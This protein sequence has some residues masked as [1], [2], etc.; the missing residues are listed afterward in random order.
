MPKCCRN[1]AKIEVNTRMNGKRDRAYGMTRL[2]QRRANDFCQLEVN[3]TYIYIC[4]D[5]YI[6]IIYIYI[7]GCHTPSML[8]YSNI[9]VLF[10]SILVFYQR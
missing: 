2:C 6:Y 8:L 9:K 3:K 7:Y 1:G 5:L 10:T 4:V